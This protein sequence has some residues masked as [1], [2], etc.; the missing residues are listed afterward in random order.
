M[1][2]NGILPIRTNRCELCKVRSNHLCGFLEIY[3]VLIV[4]GGEF[5]AVDVYFANHHSI[6]LQRNDN[7][8]LG[9]RR[10]GYVPR[11]FLDIL[12]NKCALLFPCRATDTASELDARTCRCALKRTE[13][14]F[15]AFY[16]IET[17]PE[18]FLREQHLHHSCTIRQHTYCIV[19]RIGEHFNLREQFAISCLFL[20]NTNFLSAKIVQTEDNTKRIT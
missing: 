14:Q 16:N 13:V 17:D 6:V 19:I 10:A 2:R 4:E 12:Y 1:E 20:H 9:E 3:S 18:V 8:R 7:L 11:E 15:T 5:C